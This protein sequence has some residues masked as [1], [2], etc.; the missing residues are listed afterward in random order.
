MK[1]EFVIIYCNFS[2]FV[3]C[4]GWDNLVYESRNIKS[5]EIV[6]ILYF[7]YYKFRGKIR[8]CNEEIGY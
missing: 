5:K 7:Y 3:L 2:I 4:Y 6:L 1:V 8:E